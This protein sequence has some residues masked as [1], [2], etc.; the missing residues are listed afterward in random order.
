MSFRTYRRNRYRSSCRTELTE[1]SGTGNIGG[2]YRRYA[3]VRTV[4]N[5][6]FFVCCLKCIP[7]TINRKKVEKKWSL[8]EREKRKKEFEFLPLILM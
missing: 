6:L 4:P 7:L 8:L 3:S 1:A 2:I 5:T